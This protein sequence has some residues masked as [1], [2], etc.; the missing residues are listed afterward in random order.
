MRFPWLSPSPVLSTS[1]ARCGVGSASLFGVCN[2]VVVHWHRADAASAHERLMARPC[3]PARSSSDP[4]S[5][6]RPSEIKDSNRA[7]GT[8]GDECGGVWSRYRTTGSR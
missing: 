1:V 6:S 3:Q 8:Q 2:Y 4:A 5:S 7:S